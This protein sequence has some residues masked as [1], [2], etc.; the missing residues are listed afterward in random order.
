MSVDFKPSPTICVLEW[1]EIDCG[2]LGT[3]KITDK[4]M[5]GILEAERMNARFVRFDDV[6]INV[7]FIRGAKKIMRKKTADDLRYS[8]IDKSEERFLIEDNRKKL[9]PEKS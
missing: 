4:Q 1:W 7:A 6:V 5:N 8:K 9:L 2:D 3:H